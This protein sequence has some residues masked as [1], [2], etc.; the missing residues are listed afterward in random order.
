MLR[1]RLSHRARDSVRQD[2]GGG[3]SRTP[4]QTI[5]VPRALPN[6]PDA[7]TALARFAG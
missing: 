6:L 1:A 3:R 2:D 7:L 5:Q 4:F